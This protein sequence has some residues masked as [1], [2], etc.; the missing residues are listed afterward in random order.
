MLNFLEVCFVVAFVMYR[1]VCASH[2]LLYTDIARE[3]ARDLLHFRP[4]RG[5]AC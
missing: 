1:W 3:S 4:A 5:S 2:S